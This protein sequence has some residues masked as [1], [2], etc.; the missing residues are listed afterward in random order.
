MQVF[1][2]IRR[3]TTFAVKCGETCGREVVDIDADVPSVLGVCVEI[4]ESSSNHASPLVVRYSGNTVVWLVAASW[5]IRKSD[6]HRHAH[7]PPP[8]RCL[9]DHMTE[10]Q[11]NQRGNLRN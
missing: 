8:P 1:V 11:Y 6:V 10:G 4:V 2:F 9:I 7:V 3:L 5:C